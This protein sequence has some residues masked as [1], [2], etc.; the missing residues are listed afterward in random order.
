MEKVSNIT[1][2]HAT[3]LNH[4]PPYFTQMN[5]LFSR[6]ALATNTYFFNHMKNGLEL[7]LFVVV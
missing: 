4:V 7:P 1:Q 6:Q 5:I 2:A 3:L